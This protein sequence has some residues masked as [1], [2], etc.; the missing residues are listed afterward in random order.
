M[1][2]AQ[3]LARRVRQMQRQLQ[4]AERTAMPRPDLD[5]ILAPEM[6]A[7]HDRF[8]LGRIEQQIDRAAARKQHLKRVVKCRQPRER[9]VVHTAEDRLHSGVVH[10]DV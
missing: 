3:A 1:P 5:Q 9:L 6:C 7:L 8:R 4:C 10:G 2:R